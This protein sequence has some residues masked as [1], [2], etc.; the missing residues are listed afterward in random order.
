VSIRRD[1]PRKGPEGL[2]EILSRL[3]TARGWGRRQDRLNL[4][5]AWAESV[6]PDHAAHTRPGAL[7][8]GT[9]EVVVDNAVLLQDW[10]T[11]TSAGCW[12]SSAAGCRAPP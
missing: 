9:L 2:G 5:R 12:S 1:Q 4:E 7:R 8:R 3:F 6:G 10:P 11:S